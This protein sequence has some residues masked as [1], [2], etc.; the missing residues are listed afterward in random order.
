VNWDPKLHTAISDLEV[1]SEEEDGFMWH[2]RYP[3]A[4][5]AT[6][7]WSHHHHAPETML[8]DVA[9]AVNP[10]DERYQDLIGQDICGAAAVRSAAFRSSPTITST[11]SSAPGA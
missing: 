8:G 3:L 7:W 11:P 5:G 2:F 1:L 4:D 10:N 9:V 6:T